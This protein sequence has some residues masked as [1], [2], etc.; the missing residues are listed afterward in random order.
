MPARSN[1]SNRSNPSR[2][3]RP[4][5]SGRVT[6]KGTR[7]DDAQMT[8]AGSPAGPAPVRGRFRA[9]PDRGIRP[10]GFRPPAPR[11]GTRGN[12]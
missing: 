2:P 10:T 8:P 3:S 4:G 9:G 12:R 7:P 5:P 6:P 11:A 1:R